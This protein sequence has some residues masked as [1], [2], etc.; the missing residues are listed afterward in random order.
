M[1]FLTRDVIILN[2]PEELKATSTISIGVFGRN[3][4]FHK[5]FACRNGSGA[6][7]ISVANGVRMNVSS[8]YLRMIASALYLYSRGDVSNFFADFFELFDIQKKKSN[9]GKKARVFH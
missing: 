2:S 3:A 6:V 7:F 9:N 4:D 5:I 8:K 1:S